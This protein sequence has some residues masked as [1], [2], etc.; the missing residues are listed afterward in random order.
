MLCAW[1]ALGCLR[2]SAVTADILSSKLCLGPPTP[3]QPTP[4][5]THTNATRWVTRTHT[6][7][8]HHHLPPTHTHT[9]AHAPCP[10]PTQQAVRQHAGRVPVGGQLRE[11]QPHQRG[12]LRR[13]VQVGRAAM[14]CREYWVASSAPCT[15]G[16]A[17][18]P[19]VGRA[20]R[21]NGT[22]PPCCSL[23]ERPRLPT[24]SPAYCALRPLPWHSPLRRAVPRSGL[25]RARDRETGE[26]CAL[27]KVRGGA[28]VWLPGASC[29]ARLSTHTALRAVRS[30]PAPVL[31]ICVC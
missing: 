4:P 19:N 15:G 27:K 12:H 1:A 18:P 17:A 11:A 20:G 10:P 14:L 30:H 29:A 5:H 16:A 8:H 7:N 6:H 23:K 2:S 24:P 26:I 28:A 9:H 13:R 21:H 25:C 31:I 3:P 22:P